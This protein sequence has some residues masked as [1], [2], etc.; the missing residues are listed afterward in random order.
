MKKYVLLLLLLIPILSACSPQ[1]QLQNLLR[2]HPELVKD[3]TSVR[4]AFKDTTVIRYSYAD[5]TVI[6]PCSE[7]VDVPTEI[8]Q[9]QTNGAKAT[10]VKLPGQNFQLVAEQQEQIIVSDKETDIKIPKFTIEHKPKLTAF[11]K[12]FILSGIIF[13]IIIVLIFLLIG[14]LIIKN[15]EK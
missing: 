6:N 15:F 14:F 9:V 4:V 8:A 2:K 7:D 5:T 1:K 11:Q 10:L 13:N 3:S 12:Y